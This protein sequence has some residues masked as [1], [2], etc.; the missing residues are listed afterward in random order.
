MSLDKHVTNTC[1]AYLFHLRN[2]SKIRDCLSPANTEKLVHAFITSKLDSTNSLLHGLPTF[3]IDHLQNVQNAAA[4]SST[5][6]KKYDHIKPVLKQLHWL[7]VNQ[8]D[9]KILQSA[10][11]PGS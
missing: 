7:P 6:T 11:W 5:R 9:Y 8:R 2:I 10:Q 3:L 4:R 1:K